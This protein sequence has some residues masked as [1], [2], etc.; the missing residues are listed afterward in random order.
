[1]QFSPRAFILPINIM[2]LPTG[3]CKNL[4]QN[5]VLYVDNSEIQWSPPAPKIYWQYY[6]Q[7]SNVFNKQKGWGNRGDNGRKR[8]QSTK[9]EEFR[10]RDPTVYISMVVSTEWIP[11]R[12]LSVQHHMS[13]RI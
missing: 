8:R 6:T 7:E 9:K 2:P 5:T 3:N 1:M 12:S 11:K 4:V 10:V 13:R